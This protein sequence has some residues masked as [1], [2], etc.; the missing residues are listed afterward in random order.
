[1]E[2]LLR[3]DGRVGVVTGGAQGLGLA[4]A[5]RLACAGADCVLGDVQ[6]DR[7]VWAASRLNAEYGGQSFGQALDVRDPDGVDEAAEAAVRDLGG[8]DIWVNNAGIYPPG[9]PLEATQADWDAML[10]TNVVGTFLGIQA[11]A[12]RMIARRLGGVIINLASTASYRGSG[13]YGASKW[14]VRGMTKGFASQLAA[15]RVR[16]VGIAPTLTET[17]GVAN[18]RQRDERVRERFAALTDS[19]PLG[20]S[21]TPDDVARL[22]LFLASDAAAFITGVTIPV[23][24]GDLAR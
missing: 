5:E 14:A 22:A 9:E 20:R 1:M 2:S 11:A 6:G 4:I 24:G 15:H 16:I 21:G 13:A 19:I 8:L 3:L 18:V 23:D 7:A 10:A 12:R 17:P